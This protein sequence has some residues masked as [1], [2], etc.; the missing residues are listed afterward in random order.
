M[1]QSPSAETVFEVLGDEST[2]SVFA[3]LDD[4]QSAQEVSDESGI[5]LSTVYRAL[6]RLEDANLAERRIVIRD[7][8]N[9]VFRFVRAT[10]EFS[11]TAGGGDLSLESGEMATVEPRRRPSAPGISD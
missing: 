3:R 6:D 11:V 9:R 5:P 8:G 1:T 4:P 10:D 7:D 2:R